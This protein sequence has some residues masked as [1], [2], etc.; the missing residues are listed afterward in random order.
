MR[1]LCQ[2]LEFAQNPWTSG[3]PNRCSRTHVFFPEQ[4]GG[5]NMGIMLSK[6]HLTE[7]AEL[8]GV[9]DV[10][11]DTFDFMDPRVKLKCTHRK[12]V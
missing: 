7:V 2:V 6:D 8:S 12:S 3:A 9:T 1:Y 10:D 4:Y 5:K 11:G